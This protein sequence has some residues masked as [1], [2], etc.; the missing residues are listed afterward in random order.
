MRYGTRSVAFAAVAVCLGLAGCGLGEGSGVGDNV[1]TATEWRPEEHLDD[2]AGAAAVFDAE[3][4]ARWPGEYAGVW[5]DGGVI[6]LAFTSDPVTKVEELQG[7][8]LQPHRVKGVE[9]A[10]SFEEL[11]ALQE[12]M[13]ED[14]SALQRGAP[15]ADM[16]EAILA[17]RGVYDLDID[18]SNAAVVVFLEESSEEVW[19]AFD[20]YYDS[21]AIEF[22]EG[23]AAPG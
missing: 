13:V 22:E 9:S 8:V 3:A 21:G 12:R 11:I 15:P 7:A 23:V 18:V 20:D 6:W 16:P 4:R 1:R 19:Q 14:R 17:T 2:I 10:V 5:I